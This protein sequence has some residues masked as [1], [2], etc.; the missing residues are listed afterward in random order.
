MALARSGAQGAQS[1][2]L[3]F[4]DFPRRRAM[5]LYLWKGTGHLEGAGTQL[6]YGCRG[7][8]LHRAVGS[9]LDH[10][11]GHDSTAGACRRRVQLFATLIAATGI[12]G[13]LWWIAYQRGYTA[14]FRGVA[15]AAGLLGLSAGA[16][17]APL[18]AERIGSDWLQGIFLAGASLVALGLNLLVKH[19][20]VKRFTWSRTQK[21]QG[22][23]GRLRLAQGEL[24][25]SR[26]ASC[27]DS[28]RRNVPAPSSGGMPF[29]AY[30]RLMRDPDSSSCRRTRVLPLS[31]IEAWRPGA[32]G[33]PSQAIEGLRKEPVS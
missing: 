30:R 12:A 17:L 1:V 27:A 14:A 24:E 21:A 18:V 6:A 7:W 22:D 31:A 26:F 8:E 3:T 19:F 5:D 15:V 25:D 4:D 10:L 33:T 2:A 32:S 23:A 9:A 11:G 20:P 29:D 16:A 28:S 13:T